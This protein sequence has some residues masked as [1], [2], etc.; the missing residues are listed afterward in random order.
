MEA[1]ELHRVLWVCGFIHACT[2]YGFVIIITVDHAPTATL[3]GLVSSISG[4]GFWSVSIYMQFSRSPLRQK[5]IKY[6]IST[7]LHCRYVRW[8]DWTC[9]IKGTYFSI[10]ACNIAVNR[11]LITF[12]LPHNIW[13]HTVRS[14]K[15]TRTYSCI[16]VY[17]LWKPSFCLCI[18]RGLL[19]FNL[20]THCPLQLCKD[21]T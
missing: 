2:V 14:L 7:L 5:V 12:L 17:T 21:E 10:S 9:T 4:S 18:Q 15:P 3:Q 1:W 16:I 11:P 19:A 20:F 13:L 6:H 8:R